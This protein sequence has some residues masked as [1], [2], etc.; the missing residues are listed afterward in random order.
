M[1]VGPGESTGEWPV[2][3]TGTWQL[4]STRILPGGRTQHWNETVSQC[5]DARALL[6]GY[7]G[8]GIVERAGCRQFS[9]KSNPTRFKIVSECMVR[10][11]GKATSEAIVTVKSQDDFEVDVRVTEGKKKYRASQSGHRLSACDPTTEKN[12]GD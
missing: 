5:S 8:L 12:R 3:E 7:W 9:A 6:A 11:I 2:L 4:E 1:D 10:H